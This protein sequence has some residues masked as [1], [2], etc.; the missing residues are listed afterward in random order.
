MRIWYDACTGKQV[1]YGA[2][3]ARR[4][5]EK[6]HEIIF[7]TRKHPDT[8][9]LANY[10]GIKFEIIGKYDPRSQFTR[11]HESLMRQLKFC[12]MFKKNQPDVA[13]S[14][15]SVEQCR[16]AFGLGVPIISTHDTIHADAVNRLTLPLIDVLVVSKAIPDEHLKEYPIK[17]IVKFNGV[18]E[19]A[20]IKGFE[21]KQ[22][23]DYGHPLI[24]VRQMETRA[25]YAEGRED[26]TLKVA[27]K[28][29]KYGKVIFLSRYERKP[30]KNFIVPKEFIDS[31][32]LAAE[33]DIVISVGG[34][35]AR[36]A[37]LQGTPSIV[38]PTLGYSAVNDYL[39][40]K[41]FP[42]FTI[43]LNNLV[44]YI[45][46][47]LGKKFETETLLSSLENPVDIIESIIEKYQVKSK[48]I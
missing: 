35:I 11:L 41:G 36:E 6:G 23:F 12:R 34:T 38:I 39:N 4:L 26:V 21:P 19:V 40:K 32:S 48:E 43:D 47:L 45:K 25:A 9:S 30:I 31:A 13:I 29:S 10:L 46:S 20:W 1:R 44:K 5:E 14:H 8:I 3:I 28:L 37:A 42:I 33:A 2:A 27:K 24:V 7:T 22:K 15:R 17:R 18:D 16:V